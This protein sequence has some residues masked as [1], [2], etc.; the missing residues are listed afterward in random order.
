MP[1][2]EPVAPHRHDLLEVRPEAWSLIVAANAAMAS[3]PLLQDWVM[4][5]GWPVMRRRRMPGDALGAIP[6]AIALPPEAT[7]R[8]IGFVLPEAAV[9]A[10]T[11]PPLLSATLPAAPEPC[12]GKARRLVAIGQRHGTEPRVFGS[13]M[14]QSVTGLRY[15][16]HASDLDLLWPIEDATDLIPLLR[17]IASVAAC[18]LPAVDGEV[19]FPGGEAVQWS[20]LLG[21]IEQDRASVLAKSLDAVRLIRVADLLAHRLGA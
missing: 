5:R 21:A 19:V 2:R 13:L 17:G 18:G 12:R 3:L 8:R 7:Q 16:R 15:L 1:A 9:L 4:R 20:E 11:R 6:A 10:W 14:W